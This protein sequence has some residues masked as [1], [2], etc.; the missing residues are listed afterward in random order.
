MVIKRFSTALLLITGYIFIASGCV[1]LNKKIN[2]NAMPDKE[3]LA[4]ELE[5][6]F[7]ADYIFKNDLYMNSALNIFNDTLV[8]LSFDSGKYFIQSMLNPYNINFI[9]N[10]NIPS[11]WMYKN[12]SMNFLLDHYECGHIYFLFPKNLPEVDVQ[13]LSVNGTFEKILKN[14][15]IFAPLKLV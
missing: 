9:S 4:E 15:K 1:H 10:K 13:R 12:K 2:K 11:S 3:A 8:G 14:L 7:N 5:K 6:I